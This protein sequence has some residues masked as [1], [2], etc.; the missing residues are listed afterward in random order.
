MLSFKVESSGLEDGWVGWDWEGGWESSDSLSII[1][2]YSKIQYAYTVSTVSIYYI[3][4]VCLYWE[5][6]QLSNI[7]YV[8]AFFKN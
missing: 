7:N 5:K 4:Y 8:I 6:Q 2:L 1:I 3:D